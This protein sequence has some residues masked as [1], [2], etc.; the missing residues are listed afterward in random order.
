[1]LLQIRTWEAMEKN[2]RKLKSWL[3]KHSACELAGHLGY[4]SSSTVE[5]WVNRRKIPRNRL[6]QVMEY[7]DVKPT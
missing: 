7:I 3:R 2:I 1:M 6:K 4:R 5:M